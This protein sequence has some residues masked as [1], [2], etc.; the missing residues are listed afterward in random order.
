MSWMIITTQNNTT[1]YLKRIASTGRAV[2][3]PNK[4]DALVYRTDKAAWYVINY[5]KLQNVKLKFTSHPDDDDVVQ[6]HP[7]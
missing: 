3:T 5:A 2:W 1:Y 6:H 4:S 7:V